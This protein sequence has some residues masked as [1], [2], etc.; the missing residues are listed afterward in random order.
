MMRL[1][2]RSLLVVLLAATALAC[3]DDGPSG[4]PSESAACST[5]VGNLSAGDTVTGVLSRQSCRLTDNT[6]ADRWRLVL[7]QPAVLTLEMQS[8]DFDAYLIVRDAAGNEL[9]F[10]DDGVGGGTTDARITYG[11]AAG[12]YYVLA[13]SYYEDEYGGY[14][15]IVE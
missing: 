1:A 10:D 4:P 15:L 8:D 9:V 2:S 5:T 7:T 3:G 6:A 13:N 14:T 11:F 12:T